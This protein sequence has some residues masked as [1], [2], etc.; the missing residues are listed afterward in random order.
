METNKASK[1]ASFPCIEQDIELS[2][3]GEK[4]ISCTFS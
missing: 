2:I 1:N 3:V 4:F